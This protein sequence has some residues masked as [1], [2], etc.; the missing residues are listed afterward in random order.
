VQDA[1]ETYFQ[2]A[3]KSRLT[4]PVYYVH[5]TIDFNI[6]DITLS[7]FVEQIIIFACVQYVYC[8]RREH[9]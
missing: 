2:N 9:F 7:T 6:N 5:I 8:E 4:R 1:S 3:D